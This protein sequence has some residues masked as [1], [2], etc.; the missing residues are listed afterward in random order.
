MRATR[1]GIEK[2][3]PPGR[4]RPIRC[5]VGPVSIANLPMHDKSRHGFTL[6]ELLVVVSIIAILIGILLPTVA[7]V[8]QRARQAVCGSNLRQIGIAVEA[9]RGQFREVFPLA[10]YMPRPFAGLYD[11]PS[12]PTT[13][14]GQMDLADHAVYRCP[15]DDI[16]HKAP[17]PPEIGISYVYNNSLA[18]RQMEDL[19]L[20]KHF[21]MTISEIPVAYDCDGYTLDLEGGAQVTPP[22][23]HLNR[24]LLFADGHVGRF[25]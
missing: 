13:L 21:N 23:F 20:V 9:Y 4:N 2:P 12:L 19:W 10:R 14:K 16:I 8:R 7:V 15:G 17:V 5:L 22:F 24:N 11:D 1:D 25:D 6:I 18:G 3:R